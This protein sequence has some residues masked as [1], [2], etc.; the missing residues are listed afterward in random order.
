MAGRRP[1]PQ[2]LKD[3]AGNPGKRK[4]RRELKASGA[5]ACPPWLDPV[6]KT[7][8]RRVCRNLEQMGLLSALDQT[9]LAGY[10]QSYAQWRKA[11]LV[12][13]KLGQTYQHGELIK[14]RPEVGIAADHLK[15]MRAFQNDMVMNPSARSRINA[16]SLTPTLPGI[17]TPEEEARKQDGTSHAEFF[18]NVVAIG[19]KR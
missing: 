5:A 7:E 13:R 16:P 14:K 1:K 9:A 12:V 4:P 6:A 2:V 15:A 10:C 17:P 11:S 19:A 18:D 3:L 8:W